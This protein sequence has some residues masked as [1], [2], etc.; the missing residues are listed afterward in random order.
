MDTQK[1][2]AIHVPVIIANCAPFR[3][4][5]RDSD[6]WSPTIDDINNKTYDYVKL[7]RLSGY[8]DV[9]IRPFSMEIA[10]D[11][12]LILPATEEF[13]VSEKALNKCNQTLGIL[14]L[15]GVYYEAVQPGDLSAGRLFVNGYLKGGG[16]NRSLNSNFHMAIRTK[17]I[18]PLDS[19]RLLEPKTITEKEISVAY[20]K[21]KIIFDKIEKLS[22]SLLLNGVSNYVQKQWTEALIF[23]W[24]AIEQVIDI[25]W[26]KEV[27]QPASLDEIDG[28]VKFLKDFRVWTASAKI[29]LLYQNKFIGQEDYGLLNTARKARNNFIHNAAPLD[30]DKIKSALEALFRLISLCISSYKKADELADVVQSIYKN[31]RG[32]LYPSVRKVELTQEE[33]RKYVLKLPNLPGDPNWKGEYE[34]IEELVLKP[35]NE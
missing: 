24:T 30:D 5:L 4:V 10:F 14:L 16:G 7:S 9:G 32:G 28:R 8:L 25:I 34:I 19:M 21:G 33:A 2:E 17:H 15:G 29:E 26:R 12:S 3:L 18:S 6:T 1:E 22:P 20:K 23:L 13:R 11:G 27:V 35:M 31:Q